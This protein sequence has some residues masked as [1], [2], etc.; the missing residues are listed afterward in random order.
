[1]IGDVTQAQRLIAVLD[2]LGLGRAHVATMIPGDITPLAAA[3]ADRLAGVVLCTPVFLD[4][5]P[6][7]QL[8]GR[9]L[10]VSGEY[11][12]TSDLVLRAVDRL[13]GAERHVLNGYE[14]QTWSD[15]A[16]DRTAELVDRMI[17]F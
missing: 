12:P 6:F 7:S 17:S 14:A 11:G 2:H 10:M 9:V 5:T 15:V 13:Q 8:A 4:P 3:D 1:M 16:A